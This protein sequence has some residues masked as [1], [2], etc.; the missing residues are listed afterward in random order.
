M[1]AYNPNIPQA[2]DKRAVSQQQ[3]RTNFQVINSVF[4]ENHESLTSDAT[5]RGMHRVLKL[6]TQ[7]A[8]PVTSATETAIYQKLVAGVPNLFYRP[9]NSQTPIQMTYPS[10]GTTTVAPYALRQYSFVAGPFVIYGGLITTPTNGQTVTLVPTT[11]LL[12]VGLIVT[13]FKI[14]IPG[15]GNAAPPFDA[16]PKNIVGSSFDIAFKTQPVPGSISFDVYYLAIG[17]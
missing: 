11:T 1:G 4:S 10:I 8:N 13:H 16:I 3:I 12:Y 7:V 2:G 17:Q 14:L 15:P 6:R 5:I 9:N